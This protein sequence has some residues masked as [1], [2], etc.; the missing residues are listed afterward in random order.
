MVAYVHP[1]KAR[2]EPIAEIT[3]FKVM[4]RIDEFKAEPP[5]SEDCGD[6]MQPAFKCLWTRDLEEKEAPHFP[7]EV[8]TLMKLAFTSSNPLSEY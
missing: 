5:G 4:M 8:S 7:Y 2:P 1:Q 6:L 3:D